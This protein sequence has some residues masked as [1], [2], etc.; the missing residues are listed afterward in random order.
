MKNIVETIT[1]KNI[2]EDYYGTDGK[3]HDLNA[4]DFNWTEDEVK[5]S[6]K[7]VDDFIKRVKN[8]IITY[9][10]KRYIIYYDKVYDV[11]AL[12]TFV[13]ERAGLDSSKKNKGYGII[14]NVYFPDEDKDAYYRIPISYISVVYA[15]ERATK[16]GWPETHE[17]FYPIYDFS[18][19]VEKDGH[20][21]FVKNLLNNKL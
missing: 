5:E 3:D 7:I 21:N 19:H 2:F 13:K 9:K 4:A 15:E 12:Y 18:K 1:G 17:P 8:Y 10:G 20:L 6:L 16:N 14:L 11:D